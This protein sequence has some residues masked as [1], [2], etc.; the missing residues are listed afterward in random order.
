MS[1]F[2]KNLSSYNLFNNL[3]P[4]VVFCV[5]IDK[6]FLMSII[7]TDITSGIFF[8]Y[9]IGLVISRIG[10]IIVEPILKKI[11]FLSF[12]IYTDFISASKEDLK[13]DILSETNNMYRTM[14]SM[15]LLISLIGVYNFLGTSYKWLNQS[16]SYVVIVSL[17]F[18]FAFSYKKQTQFIKSRVEK[19]STKL[20]IKA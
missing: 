6:I 5:L 15:M 11:G 4:G 1:D 12:A 7:Q 18:L 9:F 19:S 17:I 10:S 20:V 16:S 13:I 8:Y 14:L 3:L 2:F